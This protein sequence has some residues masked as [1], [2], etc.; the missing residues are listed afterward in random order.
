MPNSEAPSIRAASINS[1]GN[2]SMN[3]RIRKMPTAGAINGTISDAYEFAQPR[4]LIKMNNGTST[5][6]NGIMVEPSRMRNSKLLPLKRYLAKPNPANEVKN[7]TAIVEITATARLFTYQLGN[8][9][10]SNRRV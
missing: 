1:N 10:S 3:C 7:N 4:R 9:Q 2:E 6:W 5:I 8:N